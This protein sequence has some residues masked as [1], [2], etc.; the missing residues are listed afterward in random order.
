MEI[1]NDI[2]NSGMLE[3][4]SLLLNTKDFFSHFENSLKDTHK[5]TNNV[6]RDLQI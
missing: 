6:L 5:N 3:L 4:L 1:R 2:K